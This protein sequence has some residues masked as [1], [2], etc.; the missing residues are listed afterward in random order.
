MTRSAGAGCPALAERVGVGAEHDP[1]GLGERDG[2]QQHGGADDDRDGTGD[3]QQRLNHGA[4][5]PAR[6]SADHVREV[7]RR[8]AEGLLDAVAE[9]LVAPVEAPRRTGR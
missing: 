9:R 4:R 2:R 5:H 7:P 8:A 3:D 6:R 1:V